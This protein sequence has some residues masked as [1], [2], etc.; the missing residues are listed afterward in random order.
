M[1]ATLEYDATPPSATGCAR[2]RAP[3][4]ERLVHPSGRAER[5]R[6]RRDLRPRLLRGRRTTRGP[7]ASAQRC[8]APAPTSPGTR[9]RPR[10]YARVRRDAARH[11]AVPDRGGENGWYREPVTVTLGPRTD[12]VLRRRRL[13]PTV[14]VLGA[15]HRR[16]VA[17]RQLLRRCRERKQRRVHGQVRRDAAVAAALARQPDSNGWFNHPVAVGAHRLRR[18][19]RRRRRARRVLRAD[20]TPRRVSLAVTCRD[21]AGNASSASVSLQVRRDR[22]RGRRDAGPAACGGGVVPARADGLLRGHATRHRAVVSCTGPAR[23]DGPDSTSARVLGSCRD[24]AGNV[25]GGARTSSGTTRLRRALGKARRPRASDSGSW[26]PGSRS[27]RRR[28][29]PARAHARP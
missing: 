17:R 29:G 16:S 7:T 25:S 20:R 19:V 9:A 14:D 21:R 12:P 4:V 5:H 24:A 27:G 3:D 10:E 8:P 28:L 6:L 1:T 11:D 22:S 26:S 13:Q 2:A 23:Y 18:R 15:R